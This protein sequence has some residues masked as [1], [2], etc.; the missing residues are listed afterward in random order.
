MAR[1]GCA[2]VHVNFAYETESAG[3]T[4]AVKRIDQIVAY[5]AIL[6]GIRMAIVD[7]E[8]TILTLKTCDAIALIRTDEVS[9]GSAILTRRGFALVYLYLTV[10][11]GIAFQTLAAMTVAYVLAG[12]VVAEIL[13]GHA[14]AN[15]GVLA[16][17][18]F[19][20][21]HLAGPSGR[22]V[23]VILVLVLHARCLIL[24]RIVGAPVDVLVATLACV[25][26]GTVARVMGSLFETSGAVLAGRTVALVDAI[27]TIG[28]G[29]A[30]LA[31][32]RVVVD[33]VYAFAAVHAAAVRAILVV[34][35]TI[36]SG[37]A[38]E[39]LARVRID[40]FPATGSVQTWL[41][42]TL[43]NVDLAMLAAE[44][45]HAQ[46]RVIADS[47]QASAAV[48]TWNCKK[49][50]DSSNVAQKHLFKMRF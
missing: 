47:I 39:T 44:T 46:T 9:A 18:H 45:V 21:A 49:R 12:A 14:F 3:R 38:E 34:G 23:A 8:L 27:L 43:V 22:A 32:A 41:R 13:F 29:V 7:I 6:A 1:G 10:R 35:L 20:I 28:S 33:A 15:C 4:R 26:V 25:T 37:K 16:R 40:V 48:L 2:V 24:T 50:K 30:G 11:T 5:T 17:D 36:D 31:N 42:L 19:H